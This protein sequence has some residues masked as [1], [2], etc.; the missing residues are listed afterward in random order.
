MLSQKAK[1]ELCPRTHERTNISTPAI[2][3]A[4]F[5]SFFLIAPALIKYAIER[6][7]SIPAKIRNVMAVPTAGI[8]TNVG[9]NVPIILPTVLNAPRV[10]IVLILP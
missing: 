10:P 7:I 1:L 6:A 4:R 8:V 9:K 2:I 5:L 3:F